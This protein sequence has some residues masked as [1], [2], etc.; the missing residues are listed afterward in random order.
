MGNF[1]ELVRADTKGIPIYFYSDE[2]KCLLQVINY[3]ALDENH[4]SKNAQSMWGI[5]EGVDIA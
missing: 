2:S 1:Q 5:L 3:V 4:K